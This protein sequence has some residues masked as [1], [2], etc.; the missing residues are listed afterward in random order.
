MFGEIFGVFGRYETDGCDEEEEEEKTQKEKQIKTQQ[1]KEKEELI[2]QKQKRMKFEEKRKMFEA[3]F[4]NK[5]SPERRAR[6]REMLKKI[7][8]NPHLFVPTD[9]GTT[10]S[11]S[12]TPVI[13]S[14]CSWKSVR[15]SDDTKSL[16]SNIESIEPMRAGRDVA[17]PT[18]FDNYEPFL[19]TTY[20]AAYANTT[21]SEAETLFDESSTPKTYLPELS[22]P[23]STCHW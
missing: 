16:S 6:A 9:D 3:H 12:R 21:Q 13:H 2:K 18:K 23:L 11:K 1:E 17:A 14:S 10:T 8:A 22:S 19:D 15:E 7:A 5:V 20:D 4:P